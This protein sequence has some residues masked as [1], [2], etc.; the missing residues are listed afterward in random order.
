MWKKLSVVQAKGTIWEGLDDRTMKPP[1]NLDEIEKHFA[2]KKKK[3]KKK[4]SKKDKEEKKEPELVH[5]VGT[6]RLTVY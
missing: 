2:K 1:L 5:L 4:K 3:K 6:G